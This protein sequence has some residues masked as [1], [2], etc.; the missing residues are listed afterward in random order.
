MIFFF[1]KVG[2]WPLRLGRPLL[3]FLTWDIPRHW[4]FWTKNGRGIEISFYGGACPVRR[5]LFRLPASL[6]IH[7]NYFFSTRWVHGH[8]VFEGLFYDCWPETLLTVVGWHVIFSLKRG[9]RLSAVAPIKTVFPSILKKEWARI[10]NHVLARSG[11]R[12]KYTS[13]STYR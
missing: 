4:P 9:L 10:Q 11:S 2:A 1:H 5:T 12:V 8:C 3:R 6:N 7:R 13:I